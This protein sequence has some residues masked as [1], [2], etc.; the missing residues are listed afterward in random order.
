VYLLTLTIQ[1][2]LNMFVLLLSDTSKQRNNDS[3]GIQGGTAHPEALHT[4]KPRSIISHMEIPGYRKQCL[5]ITRC[6]A[7][8]FGALLSQRQTDRD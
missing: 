3:K 1:T 7:E 5:I 4:V 6:C 8:K 2:V